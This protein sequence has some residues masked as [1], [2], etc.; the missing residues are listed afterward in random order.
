MNT[1]KAAVIFVLITISLLFSSCNSSSEFQNGTYYMDGNH[2]IYFTVT[3]LKDEVDPE[4]KYYKTCKIQFSESYD[5]QAL[6]TAYTY[7]WATNHAIK[8]HGDPE[9]FE[10]TM[11]EYT[12]FFKKT[13]DMKKQ[14]VDNACTFYVYDVADE[15]Y[16]SIY[17]LIDGANEDF[18]YLELKL[19]VDGSI[20]APIQNG[21]G[22]I[23]DYM[24]FKK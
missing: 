21:N 5:M 3:D 2:D 8:Y 15:E 14:F 6:Q 22:W 1:K 24:I 7:S 9:K 10:R 4:G 12:E 17:A 18:A 19:D 11:T 13:V 23:V 16:D 20:F